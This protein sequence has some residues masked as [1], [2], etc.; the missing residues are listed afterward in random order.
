MS[1]PNPFGTQILSWFATSSSSILK[2]TS[3]NVI[4]ILN[5]ESI[6][7]LFQDSELNNSESQ[8]AKYTAEYTHYA[9]VFTESET[10]TC[11]RKT[12]SQLVTNFTKCFKVSNPFTKFI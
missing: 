9:V 6:N 4:S 12:F 7:V 10:L 3:S 11:E 1:N 5:I 2:S 8:T